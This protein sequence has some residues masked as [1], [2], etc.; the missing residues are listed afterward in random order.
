LLWNLTSLEKENVLSMVGANV[1]IGFPNRR[2]ERER[3]REEM[4]RLLFLG[5][6]Y[7]G[8]EMNVYI[9]FHWWGEILQVCPQI[10]TT[11]YLEA[12]FKFLY[13]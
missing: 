6:I 2:G 10:F 12:V 5:F 8:V 9:L 7:R 1:G 4:A 13:L 11:R 3:G